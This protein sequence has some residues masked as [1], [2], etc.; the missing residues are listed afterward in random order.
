MTTDKP[1]IRLPE[2][3]GKFITIVSN[4]EQRSMFANGNAIVG[5]GFGP[6]IWVWSYSCINT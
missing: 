2:Q 3:L 5:V 4:N 1:S 6:P